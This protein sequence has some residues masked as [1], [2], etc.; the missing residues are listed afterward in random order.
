MSEKLLSNIVIKEPI[1]LKSVRT[2]TGKTQKELAKHV[3]IPYTSYCRYEL[4]TKNMQIGDLMKFCEKLGITI[5]K[6]KVN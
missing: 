5:D 2:L 6:I 1:S 3:G 4:N